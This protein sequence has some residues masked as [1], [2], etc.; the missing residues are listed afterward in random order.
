[1]L[2]AEASSSIISA[3]PPVP[4]SA[5]VPYGGAQTTAQTRAALQHALDNYKPGSLS[6]AFQPSAADL[7][8]SDSRS[9]GV[10]HATELSNIAP[11]GSV[12][13]HSDKSSVP[14]T[15]PPV[16]T[17]A[18]ST[19]AATTTGATSPP[20][21][22]TSSQTPPSATAPVQAPTP[23]N[24]AAL[25]NAPAPIPSSNP[26]TSPSVQTNVLHVSP[27]EAQNV[28]APIPIAEPTVAETGVPLSAGADGPGPASGSLHDLKA[29][30]TAAVLGSADAAPAAPA[31]QSGGSS[32]ASAPPPAPAKFE[33]AEDEKKRLQREE[34]ERVL[35]ADAPPPPAD[36][37]PKKYETAEE[38]K[39]RLEKEEK[40]RLLK[41][42]SQG[43]GGPSGQGPDANPPPYQDF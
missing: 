42:G 20:P 11:V 16:D 1:M 17:A 5:A 7:N 9:F 29:K 37:P 4:P 28:S 6:H 8:R 18:V 25:N 33:S 24:P 26:S 14:I 27:Q 41:E 10:T 23:V 3:L 15:P 30:Q 34:R 40:E 36:A 21:V 19:A 2:L 22:S 13:P 38:E 12:G 35:S 43:Q 39:Q 31:Y 32:T